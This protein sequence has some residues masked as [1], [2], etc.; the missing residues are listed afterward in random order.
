MR[1]SQCQMARRRVSFSIR[2]QWSVSVATLRVNTGEGAAPRAPKGSKAHGVGR[3]K[4]GRS[5]AAGNAG[6]S[7][8][9]SDD[10]RTTPSK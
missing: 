6:G 3:P 1:E 8:F 4:N 2:C 7:G 10:R 5:R 9:Y